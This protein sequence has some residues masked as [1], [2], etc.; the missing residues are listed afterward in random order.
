MRRVVYTVLVEAF[1]ALLPPLYT[2]P[3]LDYVV[4]SDAETPPP[5]PWQLRPLVSRHRNP[6]MTARW[7]KLHPH[8]LFPDYEESLHIDAN[9]LVRDRIGAVFGEAL[10][11][12]PLALF[13]HPNRDCVYDEAEVVKRLRYDDPEIVDAQMAYYRAQGL[14]RRSGLFH[15]A[16]QFRRHND[17]KLSAMLEDWWR[18]LKL[19]SHRDQLSLSFML[20]RHEIRVAE[21]P[22][23]ANV[24]PWFMTGPHE[25]FRVDLASAPLPPVADE[26]DWLRAAFIAAERERSALRDGRARDRWQAAVRKARA[27]LGQLRMLRRRLLW[28]RNLARLERAED[29]AE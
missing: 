15:G 13:R 29:G 14:A 9:V 20:R 21:L 17:R 7:H 23:S 28:R 10:R 27:P 8:R 6:R 18:Q 25:R 26:V 2:E 24:N 1:D 12:S 3:T 22:G 16:V 19:F 4:Y 11:D 5:E